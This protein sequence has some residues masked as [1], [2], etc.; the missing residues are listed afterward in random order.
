MSRSCRSSSLLFAVADCVIV[1]DHHRGSCVRLRETRDARSAISDQ[2][3]CYVRLDV[4]RTQG[5]AADVK[6]SRIFASSFFFVL[7]LHPQ[8]KSSL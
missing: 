7:V 4:V 6:I 3:V 8:T 5:A 1:W 2:R